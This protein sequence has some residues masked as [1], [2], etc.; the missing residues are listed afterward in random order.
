MQTSDNGGDMGNDSST[1][2]NPF[3]ARPTDPNYPHH[4][5]VQKRLNS[6]HTKSKSELPRIPVSWNQTAMG[7]S[8][9]DP[10]TAQFTEHS[11]QAIDATRGIEPVG[12]TH[13]SLPTYQSQGAPGP[14]HRASGSSG[15]ESFDP[16]LKLVQQYR[17]MTNSEME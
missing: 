2:S 14:P 10:Q 15:P 9:Y 11:S 3:M 6:Q 1:H 13:Q 5:N 7:F 16:L 4:S 8:G 12:T 17:G